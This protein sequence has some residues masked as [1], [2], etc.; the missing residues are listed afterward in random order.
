MSTL[1]SPRR[2]H[3]AALLMCL[4]LLVLV[5]LMGLTTM[6]TA[7]VQEKMSGSNS[8]RTLAFQAAEMALRDAENHVRDH[9]TAESAF[10]AG[11]AA[12][13]CI[14][15]I[16]GTEASENVDWDSSAV[17]TYGQDTGAVA[18]H[19]VSQQPKYVIELLFDMGAAPGNSAKMKSMGTPYRITALGYGKQ[20][21]TRVL[22]QSTY[23]KP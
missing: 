3:G 23:Y 18:I 4:I 22:L 14:A 6:R 1:Y 12:S 11:C 19:G 9:L 20:Q 8:D 21:R 10:G 5:T 7:I 2:Q 15:P 17:G 13:L 16:D